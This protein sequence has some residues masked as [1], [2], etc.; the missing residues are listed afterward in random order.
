MLIRTHRNF[1]D[2]LSEWDELEKHDKELYDK[3]SIIQPMSTIREF[4]KNKS[5]Y[6]GVS[7]G[8]DSVVVAHLCFIC[9]INWPLVWIKVDMK[10]NPDC[11]LVRDYF[12]S[13]FKMKYFEIEVQSDNSSGRLKKGFG[14]AARKFGDNYISGVRADESTIRKMSVLGYGLN[15]TH[16]S[17]PIGK[18]NGQ[19]V[20][21]YLAHNQLPVHPAYAMTGN[22]RWSRK[23]IRVATIGGERGN[24]MGRSEWEREYY[25]DILNRIEAAKFHS[26]TKS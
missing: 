18:W 3:K 15:T 21:S 16:T 22:G 26:L 24:G 6:I 4:C 20:F 8:K 23:F 1:I 13:K 25:P 17:R 12:L 5:G 14:Y 7:W 19:M 2:D 10:Y 9:G 11:E